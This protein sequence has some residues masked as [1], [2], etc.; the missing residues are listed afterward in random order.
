MRNYLLKGPFWDGFR[1]VAIWF[2][3]TLAI[4]TAYGLWRI[5]R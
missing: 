1:S 3:P 2:A 5:F 4:L